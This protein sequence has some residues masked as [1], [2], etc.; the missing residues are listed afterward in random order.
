MEINNDESNSKLQTLTDDIRNNI[1]QPN[2]PVF[3]HFLVHELG[4]VFL[5]YHKY[6]FFFLKTFLKH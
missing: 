5:D 3:R 2:E 1:I 6:Q 4:Q